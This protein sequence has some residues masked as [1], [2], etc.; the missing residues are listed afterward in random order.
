M[1]TNGQAR[2]ILI[3]DDDATNLRMLTEILK[4]LYKVYAAPSGERALGFLENRV[5]DLIMLDVAM[6]VMSGYELI[7]KLKEDPKPC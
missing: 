6:P 7:T 4:P 5:P 1:E 3:V 2:S